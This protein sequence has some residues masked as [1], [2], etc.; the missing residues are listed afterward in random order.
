MT[1][2]QILPNYSKQGIIICYYNLD[3]LSLQLRKM[4]D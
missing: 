1:I 3:K 2:N 4:K